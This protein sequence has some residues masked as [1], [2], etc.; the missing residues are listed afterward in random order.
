MCLKISTFIKHKEV[1]EGVTLIT[2]CLKMF[3]KTLLS[4]LCKSKFV[5]LFYISTCM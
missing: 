3:I 5:L 2:V 1:V 4:K